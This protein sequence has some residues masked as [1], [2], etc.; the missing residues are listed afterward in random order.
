M[1][2]PRPTPSP[3]PAVR[4]WD[5]PVRLLHIVLAAAVAG[6][7]LTGEETLRWHEA[8]GWAGLAAVAARLAWGAR[9]GRFARFGTFVR[10][11]AA[12]V[13]YAAQVL[14]GTA[15]RYLGHNPLGG[16][17][18]VALL[19]AVAATGIT[20]WLYTTDAFWGMAWLDWL[21]RALA[22]AVLAL[23]GLHVAGVVFTGWH[24]RENL[25]AAMVHGRKRGG[26]AVDEDGR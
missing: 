15:P 7:W 22:W 12:T 11:P 14:H 1:S 25:V 2:D 3:A 8:A 26:G 18:A 5:L 4:V 20:G 16:W 24:Q 9:G 13:R 10:G 19:A 17:M 21:H 23:V 6:A